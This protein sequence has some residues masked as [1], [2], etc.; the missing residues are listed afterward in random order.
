MKK[1]WFSIVLGVLYILVFHAW[2]FCETKFQVQSIAIGLFSVLTI[3][4]IYYRKYFVNGWDYFVHASIIID[5]LLE[6]VLIYPHD[7]YYF[8]GCFAAFA[9]VLI[10]H[11]SYCT[12]KRA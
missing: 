5:I 8:Y 2:M 1:W 12:K 6:G 3:T 7:N 10:G 11:R 9:V 4:S